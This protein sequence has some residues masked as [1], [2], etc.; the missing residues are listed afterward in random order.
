MEQT[1]ADSTA[2]PTE[3]NLSD[4]DYDVVNAE[5]ME[6]IEEEEETAE[7]APEDDGF[8]DD[9]VSCLCLLCFLLPTQV[10]IQVKTR[11]HSLSDACRMH[12]KLPELK[13]LEKSASACASRTR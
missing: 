1:P 5:R 4:D 8:E 10:L 11:R 6:G 13:L 3:N 9:D 7:E 2:P 12:Q